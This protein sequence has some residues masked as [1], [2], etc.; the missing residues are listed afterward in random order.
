MTPEFKLPIKTSLLLSY[1]YQRGCII[2]MHGLGNK[3]QIQLKRGTPPI[4]SEPYVNILG[5]IVGFPKESR[6]PKF[7]VSHSSFAVSL[8]T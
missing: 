7:Y 8:A 3:Y 5:P 4:L 1:M 6:S 2:F